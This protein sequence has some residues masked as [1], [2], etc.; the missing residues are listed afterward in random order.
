M[1][2]KF[3]RVQAGDVLWD[4]HRTKQGNTTMS[5]MGEWDVKVISIDQ[6]KGTAVVSW[7]GNRERLYGRYQIERLYKSQMKKKV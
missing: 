2:I 7:N 3:E 4:R 1:A 5:R 6:E